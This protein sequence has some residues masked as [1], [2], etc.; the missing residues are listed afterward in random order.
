M[1]YFLNPLSIA[2]ISIKDSFYKGYPIGESKM[3]LRLR[4][5]QVEL[6]GSIADKLN[7]GNLVYPYKKDGLVEIDV[8]TSDLNI[9]E[10]F[11]A[12]ESS[13]QL[14][15]QFQSKINSKIKLSY[16]KNH[17]LSSVT[18]D[19]T[20]DLFQLE[21]NSYKLMSKWPFTLGLKEGNIQVSNIFLESEKDS[22]HI[23]QNE[24]GEINLNGNTKLD[25]FIFLFP[26]M[27]IWE[28]HITAALRVNPKLF[29]L[30]PRGQVSVKNGFVQFNNNIDIFEDIYS[31]I[32]VENQKMVFQS[33]YAKI[34]GGVLKAK[35][36]LSFPVKGHI[37]VNV[38]GSFAQVQFNSLPG[39][40][41]K[42]S[43]QVFLT[44]K[45]IPY[46]LGITADM[47]NTRIERE[48]ISSE[49]NQIEINPRLSFLKEN[50]EY[51]T[52]LQMQ[53][54][55]YFK[56]PIEIENSTMKSSFAG[57]IKITGDP[58]NPLLSG[59][60]KALP[61]GTIIFRDH[62]FD[63]LSSRITYFKNK[64]SNPLVDLRAKTIV[65]ETRD[66]RDTT[67]SSNERNVISDFSN[68][69]NILLR[70]KGRGKNPVFT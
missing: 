35:G 15:N 59:Q 66:V 2:K 28:G 56:D 45:N 3:T 19:V 43:G 61:G 27:R 16:K 37:P 65:Q 53:F 20:V 21:A 46:T 60:L 10:L 40:Y 70:V 69:Y 44:G 52:P 48:F 34:G 41:T 4:K 39:V 54:N 49:S 31:D 64:P 13:T 30:S 14:Y 12:K 9:K 51:F 58:L 23:I 17:F 22:L 26:F 62:E 29:D 38:A 1:G 11:L 7:I 32:Q 55:L 18:G 50:K 8:T 25:F 63:I 24:K 36:T 67:D 57:R 6:R 5:N 68:E 47:E 33:L 42:G